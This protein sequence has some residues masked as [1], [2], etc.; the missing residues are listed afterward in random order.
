[1]RVWVESAGS[2]IYV[3]TTS[4]A[5]DEGSRSEAVTT[6]KKKK[7]Q[8]KERAIKKGIIN[9][10]AIMTNKSSEQAGN[11]ITRGRGTI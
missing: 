5:S 6:K 9:P 4:L 1:M 3:E 2:K 11:M 7:K 8:G 10:M